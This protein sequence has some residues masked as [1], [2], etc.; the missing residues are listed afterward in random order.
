MFYVFDLL[1]VSWYSNLVF[2]S[3]RLVLS[4]SLPRKCKHIKKLKNSQISLNTLDNLSFLIYGV[5]SRS[6]HDRS[7]SF[8]ARFRSKTDF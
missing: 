3:N 1:L 6:G 7:Q 8:G 2:K 4:H 5:E